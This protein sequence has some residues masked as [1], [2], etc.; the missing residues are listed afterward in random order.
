MWG[1]DEKIFE[2]EKEENTLSVEEKKSG[3]G[4]LVG[5]LRGLNGVNREVLWVFR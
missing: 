3:E 4:K 5:V 1:M 2:K